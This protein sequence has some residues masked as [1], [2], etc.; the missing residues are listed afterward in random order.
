[1]VVTDGVV[2]WCCAVVQWQQEVLSVM[3]EGVMFEYLRAKGQFSIKTSA[4]PRRAVV[5]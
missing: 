1:M 5:K 2:F 4:D 3:W